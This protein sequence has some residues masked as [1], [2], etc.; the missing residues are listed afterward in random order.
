MRPQ[1]TTGDACSDIDEEI[2]DEEIP[3]DYDSEQSAESI[4]YGKQRGKAAVYP[5]ATM[6]AGFG[7]AVYPP[8]CPCLCCEQLILCRVLA[9]TC[10]A[11]RRARGYA[12]G[13][14]PMWAV[15]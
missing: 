12:R 14:C 3:T 6:L 1:T 8:P 7:F 11:R 2:A 4:R 13:P 5:S 9:Q 10:K 15:L